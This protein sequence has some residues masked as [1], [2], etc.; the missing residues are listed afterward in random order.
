MSLSLVKTRPGDA[1]HMGALLRGA[2]ALQGISARVDR[3]WRSLPNEYLVAEHEGHAQVW[4]HAASCNGPSHY[5][6]PRGELMAVA[7]VVTDE[8]NTRFVYDGFSAASASP[9][10]QAEAMA[11]AVARHFGMPV[12]EVPDPF[13]DARSIGSVRSE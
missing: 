7:A 6:I 13:A 2:L 8:V 9:I 3:P 10:Q 4:I 5:D 11:A 12:R 1:L